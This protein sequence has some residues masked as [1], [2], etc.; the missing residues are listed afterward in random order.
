MEKQQK[1]GILGDKP[2]VVNSTKFQSTASSSKPVPR[3][4]QLNTRDWIAS[5]SSRAKENARHVECN[6]RKSNSSLKNKE[7]QKDCSDK[8]KVAVLNK[9]VEFVCPTCQ[10]YVFS[11]NHDACIAQFL[12]KGKSSARAESIKTPDRNKPVDNK[13][14]DK[15]PNRWISKGCSSSKTET[16]AASDKKTTPRSYLRWIPTGKVFKSVGLRWIPTGKIFDSCTKTSN[17]EPPQDTE[18]E[19][20]T[21]VDRENPQCE[22]TCTSNTVIC[23][24]SSSVNAGTCESE[25]DE[26]SYTQCGKAEFYTT[27]AFGSPYIIPLLTPLLLV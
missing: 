2:K 4:S 15:K 10:K 13:K 19:T 21:T 17:S 18:V 6:T 24:N 23:A 22:E 1:D 8:V 12:M 11:A 7:S 25:S 26:G 14:K 3:T 20:T 27:I 9:N 5:K 16:S